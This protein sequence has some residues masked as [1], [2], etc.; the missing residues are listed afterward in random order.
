MSE[1]LGLP[2]YL[3]LFILIIILFIVTGYRERHL[4]RSMV[5]ESTDKRRKLHKKRAKEVKRTG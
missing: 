2:I 3:V 5:A 4:I 1:L